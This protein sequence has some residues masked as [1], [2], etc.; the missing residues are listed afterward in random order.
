M[1]LRAPS[2]GITV[3]AGCSASHSLSAYFFFAPFAQARLLAHCVIEMETPTPLNDVEVREVRKRPRD[4]DAR[5]PSALDKLS[6]ADPEDS[7]TAKK[8][9]ITAE[10]D[11]EIPV[12]VVNGGRAAENAAGKS[13]REQQCI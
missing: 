2:I 13:R 1:T 4:A 10:G 11:V 8:M 9:R 3:P 5:S 7:P 6:R 12:L